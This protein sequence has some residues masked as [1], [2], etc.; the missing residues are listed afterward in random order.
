MN[1]PPR[2]TEGARQVLGGRGAGRHLQLVEQRLQ[3][4]GMDALAS[5]LSVVGM[6]YTALRKYGTWNSVCSSEFM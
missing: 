4:G 6:W 1:E 5:S 3:R 2:P